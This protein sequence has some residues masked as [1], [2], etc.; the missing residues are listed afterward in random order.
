M[1]VTLEYQVNPREAARS[2][3]AECVHSHEVGHFSVPFPP[4]RSRP[5]AALIHSH[6][7]G[8]RMAHLMER[9][10]RI[11]K[12][13]EPQGSSPYAAVAGATFPS[14]LHKAI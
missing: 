11:H 1:I 5:V 13:R 14:A 9:E 2:R 4:A 10:C 6:P 3:G 8:R 7:C 12:D